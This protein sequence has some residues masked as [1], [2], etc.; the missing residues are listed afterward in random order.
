MI[1][2]A[3]TPT[4]PQVVEPRRVRVRRHHPETRVQYYETA[5]GQIIARSPRKASVARHKEEVVYSDDEPTKVIRKLVIDPT[6]KE[7]NS[8]Y[9]KEIMKKP[10]KKYVIRQRAAELPVDSDEE[11]EIPQHRQSQYVQVVQRR[12]APVGSVVLKKEPSTKYVMI[13]K[14]AESE[15][16]YAVTSS[17]PMAKGARRVVYEAPGKDATTKYVYST[18][19]KFYK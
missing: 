19:G 8:I 13:R 11:Y 18:N 16:V 14:K 6:V 15:P 2:S 9:E 7:T 1:R 17:V 4:P 5:D 3:R 10:H 12:A